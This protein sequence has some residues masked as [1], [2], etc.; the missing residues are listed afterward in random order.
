MAME[1]RDYHY[2]VLMECEDSEAFYERIY[3]SC[4]SPEDTFY[5]AAKIVAFSDCGPI[6]LEGVWING[7]EY[8]YAG[9]KPGMHICFVD[10]HT[11]ELAWEGWFPEWDH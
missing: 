9:W 2:E 5:K 11:G 4:D 8:I 10:A 7:K 3:H 6:E 1:V